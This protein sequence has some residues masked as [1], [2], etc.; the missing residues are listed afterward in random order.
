MQVFYFRSALD[1]KIVTVGSISAENKDE[2]LLLRVPLRRN[3]EGTQVE[4]ILKALHV[5]PSLG[6]RISSCTNS[7]RA[8]LFPAVLLDETH[9]SVEL[10]YK[11]MILKSSNVRTLE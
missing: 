9:L 7:S 3:L 6:C 1:L 11:E 8:C 4:A 2:V 5:S 10:A